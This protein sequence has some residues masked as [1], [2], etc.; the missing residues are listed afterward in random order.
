MVAIPVAGGSKPRDLICPSSYLHENQTKQANK[1]R[2]F[3][4]LKYLLQLLEPLYE[5]NTNV[6]ELN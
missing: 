2:F 6:Q 1:L 5:T 3:F 4:S